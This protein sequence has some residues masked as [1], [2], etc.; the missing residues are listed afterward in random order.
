LSKL[1]IEGNQEGLIPAFGVFVNQLPV[2]FWNGFANR[3]VAQVSEE[4]REAAEYLLVNAA[5]ECGYHTGHGIL[6][7]EE[8]RSVVAPMVE[9]E[10]EDILHGAFA[11]L[12]AWGWAKAEIVDLVPGERILVRAYDYYEADAAHYGWLE[13]PCAYMLRGIA[14]AFMQLAYGPPYPADGSTPAR[15]FECIQTK[16][17]E[18]GDEYGEFL[19]RRLA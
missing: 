4:L 14:A 2:E 8:W 9:R 12:G 13:R 6:H 3:L 16:G 19:V 11:V 15:L 5:F 17:L 10:P 18:C 1:E 7:C